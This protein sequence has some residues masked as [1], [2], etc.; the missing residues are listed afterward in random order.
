MANIS[1]FYDVYIEIL[2]N[3][4]SREK[5]KMYKFRDEFKFTYWSVDKPILNN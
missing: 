2:T 3:E 4:N 5:P 1:I